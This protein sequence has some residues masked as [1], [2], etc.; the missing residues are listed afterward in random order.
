MLVGAAG[1][2]VFFVISG[3][4][5]GLSD[6]RDG[7]VRF[8][9]KRVIRVIPLYWIATVVFCFFRI[10]QAS[11][12]PNTEH[13]IRS[14]LLLPRFDVS[15]FPIYFPAWTLVFEMFFYLT[16]AGVLFRAGRNTNFTIAALM[17]FLA[18]I[19]IPVPFLHHTFFRSDLCFEFAIG[20]IIAEFVRHGGRVGPSFSLLLIPLATAGFAANAWGDG[21]RVM[22]WGIPAALL[23]LGVLGLERW[24]IVRS[25]LLVLGGNAS[26]A[27]YLFQLP[28]MALMRELTQRLGRSLD[29]WNWI[30]REVALLGAVVAAGV[31]VHLYVE[32]PVTSWLRKMADKHLPSPFAHAATS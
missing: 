3:L 30:P 24:N 12:Y 4:V 9:T 1:V 15:W 11:E 20:V 28:A 8:L 2:D 23:V 31:V 17:F 32:R 19:R 27:V 14:L 22:V 7:P 26:Y 13:V 29:H 25:R 6:Y 5:I 18:A 10:H 21:D 16:Y